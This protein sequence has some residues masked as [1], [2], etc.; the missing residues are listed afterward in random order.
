[1]PNRYE[2]CND[3]KAL[4]AAISNAIRKVWHRYP[5]REQA[6]NKVH[7][8][9]QEYKKDGSPKK[10]KSNY[11]ICELC[12]QRCKKQKSSL[13]PQVHV[14]HKDPVIPLTGESISWHTFIQRLFFSGADNLQ[15]ICSTCHKAK[16]KAENAERRENKN[17]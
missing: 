5:A 16:T 10:L 4:V 3:E 15:A 17:G 12:D 9:V 6:L 1:M 11:W 2:S 14:D 8:V 13:Y 7:I